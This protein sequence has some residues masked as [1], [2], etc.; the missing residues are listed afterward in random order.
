MIH[1]L[2]VNVLL[3]LHYTQHVHHSRALRWSRGLWRAAE[4][5]VRLASCSITELG[6]VRIASGPAALSPDVSTAC[7]DLLQ[8]KNTLPFIFFRDSLSG[9]RLPDWVTKSKQ[10]TDGHLL[11]LASSH[12]ASFTTLDAGIPGAL[13]IPEITDDAHRVSEPRLSYGA[14]A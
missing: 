14:A 12:G 10:T 11:Q 5:E 13:L 7:A 3:A 9:S 1:L 6:F 8:L 2:D 4:C